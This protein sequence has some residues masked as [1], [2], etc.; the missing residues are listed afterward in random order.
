MQWPERFIKSRLFKE[1]INKGK[2]NCSLQGVIQ[3]G[4]WNKELFLS[5]LWNCAWLVKLCFYVYS[6]YG[7]QRSTKKKL[8]Y[9][10]GETKQKFTQTTLIQFHNILF[11]KHIF[12]K[13]NVK[14]M[15]FCS[16]LWQKYLLYVLS[17]SHLHFQSDVE[18]NCSLKDNKKAFFSLVERTTD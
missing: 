10:E 13:K 7:R 17:C 15:Q 16:I 2:P 5:F 1:K 8:N 14:S 6:L 4:E 9:F 12:R 18:E 11:R 3:T